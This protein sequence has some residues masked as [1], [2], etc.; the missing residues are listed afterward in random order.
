M[1]AERC[2][3]TVTAPTRRCSIQHYC[4]DIEGHDDLHECECGVEWSDEEED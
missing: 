3:S 1:S 4:C 2:K